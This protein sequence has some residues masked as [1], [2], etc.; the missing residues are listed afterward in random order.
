MFI[1]FIFSR[2]LDTGVYTCRARNDDG[3]STWTASLIVEG[4]DFF[5]GFF[6]SILQW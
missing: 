2:K 3:E 4:E 6:C 1:Y 5:E